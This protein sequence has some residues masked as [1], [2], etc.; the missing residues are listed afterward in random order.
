M[1]GAVAEI[2]RLSGASPE[3]EGET[4]AL[5]PRRVLLSGYRSHPHVG[6]QGVYLREL[7]IGLRDLGHHV[8]IASGPP[9]PDVPEGVNLVEFPSLNL[10][11]ESN[12]FMALRW[13]HLL[14]KA[15]RSEWLAHNT[16]AFGELK[17]FAYRLRD[18]ISRH[19]GDFDVIHDNQTLA[20]PFID[21]QRQIPVVATIHHPV[22]IDREFAVDGAQKRV[23]KWLTRRWY[24]F[25]DMQARTVRALPHL[26][27]VSDAARTSHAEHYGMADGKAVVAFNGIDHA[28]F[29]PDETVKR[30]SRL[31]AA[32]A[33]ADVPIKGLDVL[34]TAFVALAR[35]DRDVR[36]EM[37]GQLRD[38]PAKALLEKHRLMDRVTARS[39]VTREVI[40]D[41]YRRANVVVCPARFEGF[42]FPA[43][44]AMACGA[45]VIASDGGALP[46]VVGEAG[47]IVPAGDAAALEIAI[48]SV[49]NEPELAS[50]MSRAGAERARN[51][52][53]WRNHALAASALY[54]KAIGAC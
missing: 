2:G 1:D 4:L 12:A 24:G 11:E 32:T 9:Y 8:T 28:V 27:A 21:I 34:M 47:R 41:L 16:G 5:R 48:R 13:K 39:G 44:E 53:C 23:D 26:L 3:T 10:F 19:G 37:I 43:A 33:S 52:F 40:A 38:G 36:L 50:D 35:H 49:F 45:P 15:D 30:Q 46:E 17:A 7:A 22:A 51:V 54:E 20:T 31:I 42:G 25:T 14:S 6:G 18:W 29:C